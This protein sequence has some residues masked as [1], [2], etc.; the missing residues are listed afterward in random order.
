MRVEVQRHGDRR[1][2]KSF[3]NHL[4]VDPT[5][6]CNRRVA[7]PEVVDQESDRVASSGTTAQAFVNARDV[8]AEPSVGLAVVPG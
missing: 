4:R 5:C 7:V 6:Q 3:L 2:S 8:C 1:M